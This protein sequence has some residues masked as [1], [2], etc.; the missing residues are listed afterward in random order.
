MSFISAIDVTKT[1]KAVAEHAI[2]A[3]NVEFVLRGGSGTP[4]TVTLI[5]GKARDRDKDS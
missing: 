2:T 1:G 5:V 4:R 3:A